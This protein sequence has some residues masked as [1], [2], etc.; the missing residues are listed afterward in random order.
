[1]PPLPT[2]STTPASHHLARKRAP[3]RGAVAPL[4]ALLLV[5][6]LGMVAFGVDT[7]YMVLAQS[8]L[9]SAADAAALAGAQQLLGQPTR[10]A[11]NRYVL[12]NGFT[13]YYL[14]L[15]LQQATILSTAT[16]AATRSAQH[17]ASYHQ[18][19]GCSSLTLN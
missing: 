8:D 3:R 18:A 5:P 11:N 17:F 1:M 6:I 13:D 4:V 16:A 14:T 10:N 15:Q 12:T 2:H 19:G 9:Q 7:G